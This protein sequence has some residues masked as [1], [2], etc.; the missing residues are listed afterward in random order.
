MPFKLSTTIGNISSVLQIKYHHMT[1][2]YCTKNSWSMAC[3]GK[4]CRT[5]IN[6]L[7]SRKMS[8]TNIPFGSNSNVTWIM[9]ILNLK[10]FF[11]NMHQCLDY[12]SDRRTYFIS[13]CVIVSNTSGCSSFEK[14]SHRL[15]LSEKA[16]QLLLC[17]QEIILYAAEAVIGFVGLDRTCMA[18]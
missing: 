6:V 9:S 10:S 13:F 15:L 11:S 18:I 14:S 8:T 12:I 16:C 4:G 3:T 5:R 2:N 7:V 17:L 1:F